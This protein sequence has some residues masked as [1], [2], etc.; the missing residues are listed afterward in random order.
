MSYALTAK[1]AE[2]SDEARLYLLENFSIEM[3]DEN[4]DDIYVYVEDEIIDYI[5]DVMQI[6]QNLYAYI[7]YGK[8]IQDW[9]YGSELYKVSDDE[10]FL[11]PFV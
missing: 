1:L 4:I 11:S 8:V 6:P 7:D 10:Y 3:L 2:L 5:D 9:G